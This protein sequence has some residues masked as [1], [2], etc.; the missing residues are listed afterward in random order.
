MSKEMLIES[1]KNP[2]TRSAL[3]T[4]PAGDVMAELE[5]ADLNNVVGAGIHAMDSS[6]VVCTITT[7]CSTWPGC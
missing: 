5:D 2:F 1:W 6:G 3:V 4:S 7:E